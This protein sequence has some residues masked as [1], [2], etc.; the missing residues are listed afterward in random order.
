MTS[1]AMLA[2]SRDC[3]ELRFASLV[4]IC[5]I[6]TSF[7]DSASGPMVYFKRGDVVIACRMNCAYKVSVTD[8]N[9]TIMADLGNAESISFSGPH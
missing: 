5:R 9:D 1:L 3:L 2:Q 4:V 7:S 8:D 6:S